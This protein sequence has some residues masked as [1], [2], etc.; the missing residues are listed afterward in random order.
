M[1][2][3]QEAMRAADVNGDGSLSFLEFQDAIKMA[4]EAVLAALAAKEEK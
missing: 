3:W 2:P 4:E 1:T